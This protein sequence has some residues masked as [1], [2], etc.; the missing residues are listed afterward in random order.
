MVIV[1]GGRACGKTT[2][3]M[4]IFTDPL[5]TAFFVASCEAERRRLI[6]AYDLNNAQRN[7]MVLLSELPFAIKGQFSPKL[8]VDSADLVLGQLL[9]GRVDAA[10]FTGTVRS[11]KFAGGLEEGAL[12]PLSVLG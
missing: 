1:S 10:S 8:I 7:R 11:L 4:E 5:C 9:G 2:A 12:P 6:K 3:L